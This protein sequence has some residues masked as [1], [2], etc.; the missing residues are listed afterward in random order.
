MVHAQSGLP[1]LTAVQRATC[2]VYLYAIMLQANLNGFG[3]DANKQI[4]I[5]K[6]I[7]KFS[8]R[9]PD[10]NGLVKDSRLFAS[11]CKLHQHPYT[12]KPFEKDYG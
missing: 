12:F 8:D 11:L 2:G 10:K 1:T 6:N 9:S 3:R 4:N 5:H 7:I